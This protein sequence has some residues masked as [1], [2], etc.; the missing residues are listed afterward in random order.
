MQ[1][2]DKV[3]VEKGFSASALWCGSSINI[4]MEMILVCSHKKTETTSLKLEAFLVRLW[5]LMKYS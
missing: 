2:C 4:A 1:T 3:Q 5:N